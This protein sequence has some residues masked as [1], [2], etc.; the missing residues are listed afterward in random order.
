MIKMQKRLP[1]L[2]IFYS[3][4]KKIGWKS[5]VSYLT[6]TEMKLQSLKIKHKSK[7]LSKTKQSFNIFVTS[8][9]RVKRSSEIAK[10]QSLLS[11]VNNTATGFEYSYFDN[12]LNYLYM[13]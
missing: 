8:K 3:R 7:P 13:V 9:L 2:V 11:L 4:L 5:F 10:I 12:A 6:T 1:S